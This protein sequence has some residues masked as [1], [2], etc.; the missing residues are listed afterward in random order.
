MSGKELSSKNANNKNSLVSGCTQLLTM[1][2]LP[3]EILLMVLQYLNASESLSMRRICKK[4]RNLSTSC[5]HLSLDV[6]FLRARRVL[7]VWV[8]RNWF[9]KVSS[10]LCLYGQRYY[11]GHSDTASEAPVEVKPTGTFGAAVRF[12]SPD[13]D[14]FWPYL[15]LSRSRISLTYLVGGIYNPGQD[16]L[17]HVLSRLDLSG[18][19]HL[20]HL[21]VSNCSKLKALILPRGLKSLDASD[22][23]TLAM[24]SFPDECVGLSHLNVNDCRSL[25]ENRH[26]VVPQTEDGLVDKSYVFSELHN[27]WTPLS[28]ILRKTTSLQSVYLQS[29]ATDEIIFALSHSLSAR[30]TLLFVDI[31]RCPSVSD[32]SVV[33][34]TNVARNLE[35]L[36]VDD[37]DSISA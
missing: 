13:G 34:L 1:E 26:K 6:E 29:V 17:R 3:Q 25:V 5:G 8:G 10:G 37:C 24:I 30:R 2:S 21:S 20:G 36:R 27:R 28:Q 12:E 14:Y 11:L 31:S 7:P 16:C 22:C 32:R 23:K 35:R 4:W 18:L 15:D 9:G 33:A 19:T